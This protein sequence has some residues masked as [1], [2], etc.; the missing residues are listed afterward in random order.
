M[1]AAAC[2]EP[3]EP[4]VVGDNPNYLVVNGLL[5][6]TGSAT[7]SLTRTTT[8]SSEEQPPA[9]TNALVEIEDNEGVIFGLF[10]NEPG[11]YS[12]R[13][14][15]LSTSRMYR[16]HIVSDDGK[17]YLSDFVMMKKTPPIDSITLRGSAD[18]LDININAH[19]SSGKTKY[20]KWNFVQTWEYNSYFRSTYHL[21]DGLLIPL[22]KADY[23][24]IC[25]KTVPNDGITVESTVRFKEDRVANFTL[26]TIPPRSDMISRRYSILVKQYA[27]T[28]QAFQY[29]EQLRDNTEHIG[30][31]FDPLPTQVRGNIQ[32]I[33]HP[34]EIAI[35]F[36]IAC[37]VEETRIFLTPDQLPESYPGF[38]P[39][40]CYADTTYFEP[41]IFYGS[42]EN[43]IEPVYESG[44]PAPVGFVSANTE[45]VDC[46]VKGGITEPPDFWH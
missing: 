42:S 33:S 30:G 46:R 36:F 24:H 37:S 26:T 9:V 39:I 10:E 45:C 3:F 4:Q 7:I 13:N 32:C 1:L 35:G 12:A 38:R 41:D 20:Y 34:D 14:L 18:G 15:T 6:L 22:D 16:L 23:H 19:D 11:I 27:L 31:L 5:D 2:V 29:M 17:E 44:V 40:P 28:E 8:I 25:Y 21:V 43:V